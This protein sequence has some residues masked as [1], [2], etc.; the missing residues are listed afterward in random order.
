M[1]DF[2]SFYEQATGHRPYG[3]QARTARD[4]LP[5]VVRAPTGG[6]KTGVILAWLWRR[7]H[8]SDP[9]GTPRRLVYAL[10]PRSLVDHVSG[11]VR[12]WLENLGLAD[13][14]AVHV[15]LGS[16]SDGWGTG[17]RTCTSPR[18]SWVTP[19]CSYRRR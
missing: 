5:D 4:G 8:G 16:R 13:E 7:L 2:R 1:R 10:P 14:V 17:G 19:T 11:S 9:A 15:V 18:S 6:G 12:M 3:Y